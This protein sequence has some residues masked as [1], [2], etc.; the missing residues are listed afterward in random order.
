LKVYHIF[1]TYGYRISMKGVPKGDLVLAQFLNA[2][3]PDT[4][5]IEV[6]YREGQLGQVAFRFT[7][8]SKPPPRP[9]YP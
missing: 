2:D 8:M 4:H 7:K 6:Y 5:G 1:E 9:P 3:K